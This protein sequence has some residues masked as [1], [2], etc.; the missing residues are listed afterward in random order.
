MQSHH[1]HTLIEG[2]SLISRVVSCSHQIAV[3]GGE[4]FDEV[5]D[6]HITISSTSASHLHG[7]ALPLLCDLIVGVDEGEHSVV[8]THPMTGLERGTVPRVIIALSLYAA[9]RIV[10]QWGQWSRTYEV[11]LRISKTIRTLCPKRPSDAELSVDLLG[12]EIGISRLTISTP[13]DRSEY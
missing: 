2:E 13:S 6:G 7:D 8:A 11:V 1:L 10:V 4:V 5:V 9:D 3:V 12:W